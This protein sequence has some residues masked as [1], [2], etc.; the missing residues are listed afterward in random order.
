MAWP[1]WGDQGMSQASSQ[2]ASNLNGA[3]DCLTKPREEKAAASP[4]SDTQAA[5]CT[6]R[7]CSVPPGQVSVVV[8]GQLNK[9]LLLPH[10]STYR[11]SPS[12][13]DSTSNVSQTTPSS[14]PCWC[15]HSPTSFGS[16]NVTSMRLPSRAPS[17]L[18]IGVTLVH[19]T[20]QVSSM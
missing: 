6:G 7:L 1:M 9:N 2:G 14:F 4:S 5:V 10:P 19:K 18:F 16:S 13:I 12:P 17:F 20:I 8:L 11:L 3:T 15:S